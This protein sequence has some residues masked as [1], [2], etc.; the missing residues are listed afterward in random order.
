MA[1]HGTRDAESRGI[2]SVRCIGDNGASTHFRMINS[3]IL[4][5]IMRQIIFIQHAL[6][7]LKER[8]IS[9]ELVI[10]VIR[11]PDVVDNKGER[12]KIAQ[13]LIKEKLLRIVYDDEDE[14]IVVISAYTTS[15]V[16]K[17]LRKYDENL[18]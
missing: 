17:Y 3:T 6:D 1:I 5:Y 8:D 16:H 9:E 2:G 18:V 10:E 13:K 11:N 4:R 15:N 14:L 12:R 7:R